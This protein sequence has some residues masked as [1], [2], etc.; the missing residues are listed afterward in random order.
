MIR[1]VKETDAAHIAR[2]YN[3]Y[4]LNT[5]ITFEEQPVTPEEI[6]ARI[7][8]ITTEYPWL[9]YEEDG[10]VVGYAYAT[11]WK[12]RSA[13]RRTVEAAIY[14][15]VQVTGRHIG[16]QLTAALLDE[17]RNRKTHSVL[18]GIALPNTASVKLC[19]KF[20]FAMVGQLKEVGYKFD[21]WVDVGY[22]EL[23]LDK[24]G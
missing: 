1:L 6:V 7:K 16:S 22:W 14:L 23:V 21:Q 9:V 12:E 5:L 17:L 19:E 4:I 20:G 24:I 8:G 3:H 11:R 15:D 10:R 13:Y 18:A 2:I